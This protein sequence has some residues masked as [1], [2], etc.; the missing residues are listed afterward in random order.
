MALLRGLY[1]SQSSGVPFLP[2]REAI[3]D[4][5]M[6]IFLKDRQLNGDFISKVS[7]MLWQRDNLM[8]EDSEISLVHENSQQH[9]EMLE[10]ESRSGYLKLTRAREW[11]SGDNVAPAKK[12]FVVKERQKDSEKRKKLNLLKYE[13]LKRELLLLT[14]GIGAACSAYCLVNLSVQAAISYASGVL[15]RNRFK[16]CTCYECLQ[17][18]CSVYFCLTEVGE[19]MDYSKMY[20]CCLYLQLLYHH[21][22]NLSRAAVAEAFM[23]KKLKKIGIRSEDLKNVLEK[24]LSGTTLALSSPRLVIPAAIYGI[25]ALSHHFLNSYFDFQL[26]PG[27]FGFFAYKAAALVQVYRDNEDLQF[28]FP[29]NEE[30]SDNS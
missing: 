21:T 5:V 17:Q 26:V 23:Q 24:T 1:A 10:N 11:V 3:G 15:F 28:V 30:G 13:A 4:D 20:S 29:D 19:S 22:D 12:K 18:L 6:R 27:M 25:W 16:Q 8:H 14:T 7:D 2:G 9:D